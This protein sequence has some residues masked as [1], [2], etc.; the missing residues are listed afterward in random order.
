M[1][2]NEDCGQM[3]AWY[4][5]SAL[6]FYEVCPGRPDYAIGSPLFDK[7]VIHLASGKRFTIRARHN[8]E[9]RPYIQSASLDGKAF[10]KSFLTHAQILRG[11]ELSFDMG[12]QPSTWGSAEADRPHSFVE[13][14]D[15]VPAPASAGESV[16]QGS[17]RVAL[18]ASEPADRIHYTL[19]GSEPTVA[20]PV[21]D[22]P[23][24]LDR[25]ATLRF[26]ARRGAAWSPEVSSAFTRL[27]DWPRIQVDSAIHPS[28]RASGPLALIDGARGSLDF[29][30][31]NWQGFG[32]E[33]LKATLDLGATTDLHHLSI[34]FLQDPYTWTY[35]PLEVRFEISEDGQ[36]W[37]AAGTLATP[38]ELRNYGPHLHDGKTQIHAYALDLSAR[39]RY[40][41]VTA[42]SPITIPKGAWREGK[43]C[44]IC[45][46]EIEVK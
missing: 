30:A 35:F 10:T 6:G 14:V 11:G 43:T 39:A 22:A 18:S 17:T 23:L 24:L 9:G 37:S 29:R 41:R 25:S 27:P 19:D 2:G 1:A 45:A 26:R 3:S 4:V 33:D 20:S 15:V 44:F 32:G 31:G 8:G 38:A 5:L 16:F 7:A 34:A 21:Y 28:F 42:K 40:M 36:A 12:D 13:D 46:D